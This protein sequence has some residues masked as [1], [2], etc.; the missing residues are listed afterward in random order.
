MFV[1]GVLHCVKSFFWSEHFRKSFSPFLYY[2]FC[3]LLGS[4]LVASSPWFLWCFY[5]IPMGFQR[6][7]YGVRH[8]IPIG[9]LWYSVSNF[10]GISSGFL[11]GFHDIS[12]GFLWYFYDVTKGFKTDFCRISMGFLWYV[13]DVSMIFL[14]DYYGISVGFPWYFY[15]SSM[16]L[17][18]DF[19]W[20]QVKNQ[21]KTNWHQ[22]KVNW[23]QLKINWNYINWNQL[24]TNWKQTEINWKSIERK[25][26]VNWT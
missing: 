14:W 5:G 23:N 25:L 15:D 20:K 21:L 7:V 8:E 3:I 1:V 17:L 18:W 6:D 22:L 9:F 11:W 16:W 24:K 10:Y 13:H 26:K 19:N 4:I 2:G 12:I